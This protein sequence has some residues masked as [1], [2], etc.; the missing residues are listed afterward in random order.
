MEAAK[1]SLKYVVSMMFCQSKGKM[2]KREIKYVCV[3][4]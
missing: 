2:V 1:N 3:T 4:F